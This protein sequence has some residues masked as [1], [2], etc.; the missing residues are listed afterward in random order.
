MKAL[1]HR[2]LLPGMFLAW[3]FSAANAHAA[4]ATS[5]ASLHGWYAM[6][7]SGTTLNVGAKFLVGAILFDGVSGLTGNNVYGSE[8]DSA[9][10]GTY[11]V[12]TDCTL[13]IS[14]TI[15]SSAP[16]V[17]TV[18]IEQ[19]NEAVG[20][21]VDS[22]AVATIDLQA[23][24]AT[25]T[26]GLNFTSSSA[27]GEFTGACYGAAAAMSELHI[28]TL[29]NGSVSGNGPI[30]DSGS[31][32]AANNPYTGTYTVNSDGTFSG[33][34]NINGLSYDFYGVIAN[35]G[36]ELEYFYTSVASGSLPGAA[37]EVCVDKL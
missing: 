22:S 9:V 2:F 27:N 30:N 16:Q 19:S 11:A 17:Y 13:T 6:Q 15:G 20:I 1:F 28:A 3:L 18:A 10:T 32:V 36:A 25:Y 8:I 35:G 4:C 37:F 24:Y 29:S 31:F 34:V 33:N 26:P 23:Q 5:A 14:M 7:V 21:E 12:N